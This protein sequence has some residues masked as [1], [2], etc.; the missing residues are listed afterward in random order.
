MQA[1]TNFS[2]Q[3]SNTQRYPIFNPAAQRPAQPAVLRYGTPDRILFDAVRYASEHDFVTLMHAALA[4]GASLHTLDDHNK[5]LLEVAVSRHSLRIV[6]ALIA[7]G[8]P[9]PSAD[10]A[11]FDVLMQAALAGHVQLM[12]LLMDAFDLL[13]DAKDNGGWTAL[14]YAA[15]SGS[16][17]ALEALLRRDLECNESATGTDHYPPCQI[18][19][20]KYRLNAWSLTPLN[21]AVVCGHT[22]SVQVLLAH[23]AHG[24]AGVGNTIVKAIQFGDSA[25][26]ELLLEHGKRHGYL[27]A[28]LSHSVLEQVLLRDDQT[29]ML[30]QL[31]DCHRAHPIIDLDLDAAL[32]TTISQEHPHQLALLLDEGARLDS[33]REF[34][35]SHACEAEDRTLIDLLTA[36]CDTAFDLLML[37]HPDGTPPR[38]LVELPDMIEDTVALSSNGIFYSLLHG[39]LPALASLNRD[40]ASLSQAQI[41]AQ[42]AHGLLQFL[43]VP[44]Q[45]DSDLSTQKNE[46][47]DA[48]VPAGQLKEERAAM[49]PASAAKVQQVMAE[50]RSR[51]RDLATS[52]ID[53]L[54]DTLTQCLSAEFFSLIHGVNEAGDIVPEME[55]HLRDVAGV[56]DALVGLIVDTWTEAEDLLRKNAHSSAAP[57]AAAISRLMATT[58]FCKLDQIKIDFNHYPT[59]PNSLLHDCT[60]KLAAELSAQRLPWALLITHPANFLR[61]LE[62]RTG[63][64]AVSV[65]SLSRAI[66]NTTGLPA[67]VCN[68]V[69]CCWQRAVENAAAVPYSRELN[70]RFQQVDMAFAGYWQDWL[71]DHTADAETVLFPFTP[72]EVLDAREWCVQTQQAHSISTGSL[73]RKAS[74]APDGAP[75]PKPPRLQ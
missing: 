56:P 73:K 32:A 35:W 3:A 30:R 33:T 26:L 10:P 18:F 47:P 50:R 51:M 8:A 36:S 70:Q 53:A 11:G 75:P 24:L 60:N 43:P 44:P 62:G 66:I 48:L 52:Q 64:R 28:M 4:E 16:P 54:H 5:S 57:D 39:A 71:E 42:T 61:K 31:L 41:A 1:E 23:G 15:M 40:S 12:D 34:H 17:A 59:L 69:A 25:M 7:Q 38:L 72:Q 46:H 63:L 20:E 2:Y 9:L 21:I 27:P 49:R 29:P 55:Y 68:A 67:T 58:L 37:R 19:G 65:P 13:P 45:A 6:Q 22:S 74:A 14:H